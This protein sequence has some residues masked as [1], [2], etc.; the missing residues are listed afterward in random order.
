MRASDGRM[1]LPRGRAAARRFRATQPLARGATLAARGRQALR[2]LVLLAV[3]ASGGCG[4]SG[5]TTPDTIPLR[6]DVEWQ[7]ESF[8]PPSGPA[9]Q[10]ADPNLYTVRFGAD[11]TLAARADCNRCAGPYRLSGASLM[12]GP[13]ACTLAACPLPTLGDQFTAALSSVASYVQTP[14]ELV[15]TGDRGTLHF[16]PRP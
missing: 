16:R 11:G 13:L 3:V 14:T 15:L 2:S 1:K 4:G 8:A 10:V 6:T 7:L 12:V 9:V 5:S